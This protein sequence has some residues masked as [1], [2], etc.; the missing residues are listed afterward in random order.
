MR[1]VGVAFF[2]PGLELASDGGG[3]QH[4]FVEMRH[5]GDPAG[6]GVGH[7]Y[8]L[9]RGDVE[10]AHILN[11]CLRVGEG[12]VD[13]LSLVVVV[14]VLQISGQFWQRPI[15]HI[16]QGLGLKVELKEVNDIAVPQ[17]EV[18]LAAR[19]ELAQLAGEV[20]RNGSDE[21]E[22]ADRVLI[23]DDELVLLLA[24][25]GV[26]ALDLQMEVAAESV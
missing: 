23:V 12:V 17:Y 15:E 4:C 13:V 19:F 24:V 9:L 21:I 16:I 8:G 26:L 7:M 6:V 5:A 18:I 1:H 25:F 11:E 10:D 14:V 20:V 3:E 2:D 22:P